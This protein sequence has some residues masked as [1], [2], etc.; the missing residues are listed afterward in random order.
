METGP[1]G[2]SLTA[3]RRSC[4]RGVDVPGR[5]PGRAP[6]RAPLLPL[7][8][9]VG[10]PVDLPLLNEPLEG[11]GRVPVLDAFCVPCVLCVP[12]WVVA[13]PFAAPEPL[14]G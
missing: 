3:V 7:C 9:P 12:G 8:V 5:E 1:V 11:L 6:G 10:V 13:A 2:F 14:F 4:G